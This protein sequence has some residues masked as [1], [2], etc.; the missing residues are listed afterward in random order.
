VK[1]LPEVIKA[2]NN[3]T[4]R[5]TNRKPSE[6][7]EDKGRIEVTHVQP[8][9]DNRPVLGHDVLVRYLYAPGEL[10]GG[11]TRRATDPIW[12]ITIHNIS[13]TTQKPNQ[14]IMYYL[15]DGPKRSFVREELQVVPMQQQ[16]SHEKYS[17]D[18]KL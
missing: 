4:T 5:L 10:E 16:R 15:E 6:A 13:S 11:S 2:L 9:T 7:I 17:G 14:P 12:S 18:T 3:E 1:R 8:K